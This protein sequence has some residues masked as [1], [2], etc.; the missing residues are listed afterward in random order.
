MDQSTDLLYKIAASL[1]KTINLPLLRQIDEHDIPLNEFLEADDIRFRSMM[2]VNPPSGLET[3][4]RAQSLLQAEEEIKF[5]NRHKIRFL[6]IDDEEYPYRLA[7]IANPPLG[8]FIIGE[9]NLNALHPIS[10]V[11]TRRMTP[12]GAEMARS[13]TK[14]LARSVTDLLVVSG[15]AFGIDSIGHTEALENNAKTVAVVAHG[16]NMIYPAQHRDLAKRI[17][18]NGGAI[19]SQYPNGTKPFRNNFLE[20]NR[21]VAGMSDATII[22]E[23]EIKG[24]AMSTARH[25]LEADREVLAIPGRATDKAS[26]GCNHL[27]RNNIAKLVT[28][29]ADIIEETGWQCQ[30]PDSAMDTESLFPEL[31]GEAK[32]IYEALATADEPMQMD[33]LCA[34]TGIPVARLLAQLSELEFDGVILRHPGNRFSSK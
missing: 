29:A 11:G 18:D 16:L 28:C 23:S 14:D 15:L 17:L 30:I 8:I 25:A 21:I 31:D 19:I 3:S 26:S 2:G 12:Y 7:Q 4:V 10:I 6:W 27:I 1:L 13:I 5:M 20:R 9:C 32:T 24:G 34:K 33:A 22:V